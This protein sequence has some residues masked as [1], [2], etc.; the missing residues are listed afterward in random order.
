MRR[1]I[2]RCVVRIM[3][4]Y[5]SVVAHVLA[6]CIDVGA[7]TES[8]KDVACVVAG[9]TL[10]GNCCRCLANA[11]QAQAFLC[12]MSMVSWSM[13][14][15]ICPGYLTFLSGGSTST[16]ISSISM[17][18]CLFVFWL[19]RIFVLSVWTSSYCASVLLLKSVSIFLSWLRASKSQV[20]YAIF[21]SRYLMP[22]PFFGSKNQCLSP[23]LIGEPNWTEGHSKDHLAS[24]LE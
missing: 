6:P 7:T 24:C 11:D 10:D 19:Q 13:S 8:K 5:S 3:C 18:F 21:S 1:R 17:S 2:L 22:R 16:C 23:L 12:C 14:E 4:S 9:K 20:G 15:I